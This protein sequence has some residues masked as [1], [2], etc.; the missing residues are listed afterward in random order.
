MASKT[1]KC[2]ELI[3]SISERFT[4][5]ELGAVADVSPALVNSVLNKEIASGRIRKVKK[6][7]RVMFEKVEGA[8]FSSRPNKVD[9]PVNER[10]DFI[11]EFAQMVGSKQIPSLLLTGQA[12]VGKTHVVI[13]ALSG[14]MLEEDHDYKVI[15]GHSSDFGMYRLLHDNQEGL[16]VLDDMDSCWKSPTSLNLLKAALDSYDKRVVSWHS[17][18]TDRGGLPSSFEFKGSIIFISNLPAAKLDQAVVSRTITANLELT[19]SE[20][21]DRMEGIAPDVE[22]NVSMSMK[23]EVIGFL[24]ENVEKFNALSLRTFLQSCRLRKSSENW[25]N[26][27]LY[28]L[29]S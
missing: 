21:I 1:E 23:T 2:R 4:A 6:G 14:L 9:L 20:I 19:N 17:S 15:K 5:S 3:G 16:L 7:K 29:T 27:I 12:G 28:T 25:K 22:P 10:F 24:R 8:N 18:Q 26:M 13:E 11:F